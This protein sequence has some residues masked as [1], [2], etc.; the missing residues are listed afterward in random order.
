MGRLSRQAAEEGAERRRAVEEKDILSE[1]L[2]QTEAEMEC[3]R[4]EMSHKETEI[5]RLGVDVD[6]LSKELKQLKSAKEEEIL[7]L[8]TQLVSDNN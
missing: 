7:F 1:R 6:E 4:L 2:R 5:S 8:R 3:N